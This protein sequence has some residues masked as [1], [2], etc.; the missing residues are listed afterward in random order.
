MNEE[1]SLWKVRSS[2]WL[3]MAGYA[4]AGALALG[5]SVGGIFFPPAFIA[6]PLPL[7]YALW[8]FLVIRSRV[9]ELTCERLRITSGV[10]NQKIDEIELYRIKDTSVLRPWWMRLTGLSS[11]NLETSDRSLP[12]LTIPGVPDGLN[13]R[14]VLR[15]QV[16][17]Q[18]DKKRVREMD[19]EDSASDGLG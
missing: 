9:Y 5:I 13:L 12:Q 19:F 3:G 4:V 15:K 7:L 11:I 16:E 18:R 10:F 2:H 6:L 8:H 14:E 17:I 1:Q